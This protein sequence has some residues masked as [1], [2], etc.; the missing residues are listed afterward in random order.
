MFG[1]YFPL[2]MLKI[3]LVQLLQTQTKIKT[4]LNQKRYNL[5]KFIQ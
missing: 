3:I 5:D 4:I 2:G 1:V